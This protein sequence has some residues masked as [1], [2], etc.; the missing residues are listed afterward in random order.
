M[1]YNNDPLAYP[2]SSQ[3]NATYAH[4]GMVATTNPLAAQI[5][6]DILKRGGNAIDAAIATAAMLTVVEPTGCG[7]GG[8]AFAL[9]WIKSTLHGL[10][11]S[12]TAPQGLT[13][14]VL[15]E[16][17]YS[18]T[19]TM[20]LYGW[21]P[22]TVPGIPAAW[23]ALSKRWGKLDFAE[24]LQPAID[25]AEGGFPVSPTTSL[26]WARA[27][28]QFSAVLED[29]RI[30]K[31]W[32]DTFTKDGDAPKAGELFCSPTHGST[33]R[34]IAETHGESFYRGELADKIDAFSRQTG[35]ILRKEDLAG[36]QTEWVDPISVNYRGYD[37]WEIPPNGQGMVALMALNILKGFDFSQR[38]CARTLHRQIEAMKLAYTDGQAFIT[39]PDCMTVS[40]DA[41]LSGEYAEQ[42]RALISEQ[43]L[44]PEVGK[45]NSGGTVYLATADS[46][47]NMVSF[48]Q[49]NFHGFGSGVVVPDT[50][51][52]LQNRGADYSLNPEHANYLQP[53][54][55]SF[56]TIIP[57]F[58]TKGQQAVGPFG[59]MGAYMQPQ[60]QVQV[61]MNM[62]DF[63]MNPQAA[64]DA[65]RWQW[66]GDK[67]VGLE[68]GVA[69]NIFNGLQSQGHHVEWAT[70]PSI[71]GRGQIIL[72]NPD[73]GVLCGG[74]EKRADGYIAC[75]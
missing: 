3:R 70:D 37:I 21:L 47:G 12:S 19:D 59:V 7:I 13:P 16:H 4:N 1:I 60:G 56:H 66:F 53:G 36:Y 8:D 14:A 73:S 67:T 50:G 45:P 75:Y 27:A 55:K 62:I 33:L 49:S 25:I 44:T 20:P 58:I 68:T 11:A 61:V 29:E 10:N 71:Y 2:Y 24:L 28:K 57:G 52:A 42:R 32:F 9:V 34:S 41:L 72:R 39:Q 6:V 15:A 64:L 26:L 22:V 40:V 51:I 35:G 17:G 23:S 74:T 46:D 5:G 63:G 69:E 18:S 54:K 48:I 30:K 43:A 38:D 65:P 31:A